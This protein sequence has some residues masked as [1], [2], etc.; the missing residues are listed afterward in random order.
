MRSIRALTTIVALVTALPGLAAAQEGRQFK[1]AWFWG[2]KAGGLTFA[3]SGGAFKQAPFVGV[4]TMITRTNGGLYISGSQSFLKT[5]TIFAA[6]PAAPDSLGRA[7]NLRNMRRLDVALMGFPGT[8]IKVHPYVGV[9]FTMQQ[10]PVATGDGPF[11]SQEEF[12]ATQALIQE[13]RVGFSPLVMAGAQYRLRT[14]S[15]FAQGSLSPTQ[16]NFIL[17]N[18]RTISMSYEIGARYNIGSSISKE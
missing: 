18:G 12:D 10:V 9:G 7:I 17:Y 11:R 6:N 2:V 13:T 8:H 16:K 4:E 3:D 1:D 15:V 5:Q 14:M